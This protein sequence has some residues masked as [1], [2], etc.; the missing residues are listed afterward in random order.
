[1]R[2]ALGPWEARMFRASGYVI[3]FVPVLA[4]VLLLGRML[5]GG[6]RTIS[7]DRHGHCHCWFSLTVAGGIHC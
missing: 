1:M 7:Q 4:G 3:F 6:L 5:Q 2:R